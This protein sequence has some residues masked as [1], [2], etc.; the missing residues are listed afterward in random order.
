MQK[1]QKNEFYG[2]D[3]HVH[4]KTITKQMSSSIDSN[5]DEYKKI[6]FTKQ[7]TITEVTDEDEASQIKQKQKS[8][9]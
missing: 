7:N 4:S 3:G 1:S 9:K 5:L 8:N 6:I 2:K